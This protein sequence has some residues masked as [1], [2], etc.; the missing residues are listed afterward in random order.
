MCIRDSYYFLLV[1]DGQ[2][3]DFDIFQIFFV[4]LV[5]EGFQND[6]EVRGVILTK[7]QPK[8]SH[9]DPV[10]VDFDRF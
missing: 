7:F 8:Q 6:P 5:Q 1:V 3:R 2:T 4:F 10:D 9:L